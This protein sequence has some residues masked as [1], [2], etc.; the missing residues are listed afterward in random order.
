[1]GAA[2]A[3]VGLGGFIFPN[4][5]SCLVHSIG[6]RPAYRVF[7]LMLWIILVPV[8]LFWVRS[9]PSD[10]GLKPDDGE[11][12]PGDASGL[13]VEE[14]DGD[15]LT[16]RQAF[17]IPQF[18]FLGLGD[19]AQAIP[20]MA[21]GLYM[22]DFSIEAGIGAGVAA[23]AYSSISAA[24]MVGTIIAGPL[25]DR[26]NRRVLIS[27]SYGLPA[28]AVFA[29]FGLKSA[30][31]LF[32]FTL[33]AGFCMGGRNALWP[34]VVYDCFGSRFYS[35]VLGFLVIFYGIGNV[36]GPPLAG[37]ISD[38]TGGFRWVF[39]LS[40]ACFTVSGIFVAVG[41]KRRLRN[42]IAAKLEAS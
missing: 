42:S 25:A 18:W 28:L 3:G 30:A 20:V 16:A 12:V 13:A 6:W 26:L 10:I 17:T 8:I 15:S 33:L 38:A 21:L 22:V 2:M 39:V 40:I 11:A 37:A 41:A 1:M 36:I 34:L 29:L 23:L 35:S 27:L 9:K 24:A 5:T 32:V 4:L 31:P 14:P 19:V 7:G